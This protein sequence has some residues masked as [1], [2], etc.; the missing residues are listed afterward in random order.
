MALIYWEDHAF[1]GLVVEPADRMHETLATMAAMRAAG[2]VEE[3]QVEDL[4]SWVRDVIERIIEAARDDGQE[5]R[6][7]WTETSESAL[8]AVPLPWDAASVAQWM[9]HDTLV[10]LATVSGASPG[11]HIDGYAIKDRE[12]LNAAMEAKGHTLEEHPGLVAAFNGRCSASETGCRRVREAVPSDAGTT[13]NESFVTGA[14]DG[15]HLRHPLLD[16]L[17]IAE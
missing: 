17:W 4:P 7:N 16:E 14:D 12:A 8:D 3:L 11:G 10:E 1:H 15:C 2:S 6:W 5:P 9:G 13:G